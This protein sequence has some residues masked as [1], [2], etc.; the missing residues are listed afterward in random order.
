[1]SL[2]EEISNKYSG[3]YLCGELHKSHTPH[4][5]LVFQNESLE[6]NIQE[7]KF[8]I[9]NIQAGGVSETEPIRINI[10]LTNPTKKKISIYPKSFG[11][12]LWSVLF[13]RLTFNIPPFLR[14]EFVFKGSRKWLLN[15]FNSQLFRDAML[16][17]KYYIN[18]N[19][20]NI[21]TLTPAYGVNSIEEYESIC[22]ILMEIDKANS[23]I[24]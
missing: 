8:S 16:G 13:E 3:D 23:S 24:S 11:N 10:Y 7:S 22:S 12:R 18:K 6:F 2:L 21:V 1:M 9:K 14:Q 19:S 15:V 17:K 20:Q 4:G 5:M